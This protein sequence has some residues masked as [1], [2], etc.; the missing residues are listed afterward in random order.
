MTDSSKKSAEDRLLAI[1]ETLSAQIRALR[2]A[3][4][5]SQEALA[6]LLETHQS[7]VCQMEDPLYG[8]YSLLSLVKVAD[9]FGMELKV[10]LIPRP[11]FAQHLIRSLESKSAEEASRACQPLWTWLSEASEGL[12][13]RSDRRSIKDVKQIFETYYA[14]YR[15]QT[16]Y[17]TSQI[18]GYYDRRV[19]DQIFASS[20][21]TAFLGEGC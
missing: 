8:R 15:K 3:R 5:L 2:L 13:K 11:D 16:A 21:S 18:L 19:R 9:V 12:I 10:S 14:G 6:E 1:A 20:Q 17:Y 7:R 4:G